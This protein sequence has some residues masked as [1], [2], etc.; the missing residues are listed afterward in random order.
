MD[1]HKEQDMDTPR[2]TVI[3][4]VTTAGARDNAYLHLL[5]DVRFQPVFILGDHRSGTTLLY[6]LLSETGSF[7]FVTAYHLIRENQLLF[8]HINGT[9]TRAKEELDRQ[10]LTL[11]ITDRIIDGVRV[12]SEL[13]EEY[14]FNL[15]GEKY[16]PQLKPSNLPGFLRLCKK[17]QF[18][19]EPERPLL[20]KNPWDYLNFAYVK[21]A[22]P[23]ARFVFIHRNPIHIMNSQ[24]H[25]TRS[26]L[27]EKNP[28]A[29]LLA[30]WY[31]ELFNRPLRLRIA[32]LLFSPRLGLGARAVT[33]HI[34][35]ATTYFLNHAASLPDGDHISIRYE[36]LCADPREQIEG[37]L[38]FLGLEARAPLAYESYIE[39]RTVRL[40]PEVAQ[41]EQKLRQQLERYFVEFG[42]AD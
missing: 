36:D 31:T 14:G 4:Q 25:A 9:T 37:I 32:R 30:D 6:R 15:E 21:S 33:R 11:G 7:N 10:F 12:T 34:K 20:L 5:D 42:Y 26:L 13:P 35:R 29:A 19:S 22:L 23:A 24:L 16:R 41:R 8:H 1:Y 27:A 28:Y 40:L 38:G 3:D 2:E 18:T 17:I 39:T